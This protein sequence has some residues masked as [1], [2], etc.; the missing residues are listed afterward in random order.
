MQYIENSDKSVDEVVKTIEEKIS[1]YQFGVLHIHNVKETLNSKG[2]EFKNE[3]RILDICKPAVAQEVLSRDMSISS[4][5]PCKIS[6]YEDKGQ[7]FI[8]MNSI[9]QMIDD[10][11]PDFIDIAQEVQ[12]TLLQL[13]QDVK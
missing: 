5:M 10:L 8:A 13:I 9:V 11:N 12:E 2:L 1:D 3:C 4:M 7:T 6:V